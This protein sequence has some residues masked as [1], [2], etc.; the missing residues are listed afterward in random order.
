MWGA[1]VGDFV[2]SAQVM[3]DQFVVSGEAKWEQ[4]S[5]LV[6]LLPHGYEGQGPEHSS[7]RPERFLQLASTGNIR[8]ANCSTAAQYFHL[9]RQQALMQR[10]RPLVIFTPKSLLRAPTAHATLE[11][12]ATGRFQR[13][14]DDPE[15][16][17]KRDQGRTLLLTTGKMYHDLITTPLP[18]QAQKTA[19]A[20]IELLDPLPLAQI[21]ELVESYPRLEQPVCGQE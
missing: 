13:V 2:N 6:L 15:M 5:R 20:R 11:D 1:Q 19:I 14:I 4:R 3:I 9:L 16:S 17:R 10:P 7:A 8:V 18:K 12:L 21:S